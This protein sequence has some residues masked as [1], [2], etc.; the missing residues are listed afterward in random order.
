MLR[1]IIADEKLF[2]RFSKNFLKRLSSKFHL[3]QNF[4]PG[5]ILFRQGDLPRAMFF[6][7]VG[8]LEVLDPSLGE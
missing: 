8:T 6:L 2:R 3:M 7:G 4:N 5:D 1:R